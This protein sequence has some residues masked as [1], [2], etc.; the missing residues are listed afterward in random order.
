M[1]R[2]LRHHRGNPGANWLLLT[3]VAQT[4]WC[5]S[6][7]ASLFELI[8]ANLAENGLVHSDAAEPRV[9][10][11]DDGGGTDRTAVF[12]VRDNEPGLPVHE[13]AVLKRG[14]ETAL[15]HGNGLGL[16]IVSWSVT[17]LGGEIAFE[18][19]ETGTT[20]TVRLPGVVEADSMA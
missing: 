10:I 12:T 19:D 4:L 2:Y 18:T 17:A 11:A 5:F 8:S 7:G 1:L 14:A 20:A 13:P 3:L 16:R 15:E 6:Y 9:T